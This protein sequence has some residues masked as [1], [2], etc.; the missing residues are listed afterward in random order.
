VHLPRSDELR[1]GVADPVDP[2]SVRAMAPVGR[3]TA[4]LMAAGVG[5]GAAVAG[6]V[7][8]VVGGGVGWALDAI[9]RRIVR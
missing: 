2:P 6:S 3:E 1:P 5:V 9:R 8:A 7:G 4:V